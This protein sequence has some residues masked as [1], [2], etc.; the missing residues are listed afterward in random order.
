MADV[1][2]LGGASGAGKSSICEMIE[3]NNDINRIVGDPDASMNQLKDGAL[4]K[5]PRLKRIRS[6]DV[7][8]DYR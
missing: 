6:Q 2:W 4:D 8:F 1:F 7:G 5:D 3:E